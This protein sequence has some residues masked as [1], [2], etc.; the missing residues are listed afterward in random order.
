[1]ISS[2]LS[3]KFLKLVKSRYGVNKNRARYNFSEK[4]NTSS[5]IDWQKALESQQKYLK[6]AELVYI[7]PPKNMDQ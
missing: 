2:A 6:D 4:I 3:I 7:Y 1:M 5:P